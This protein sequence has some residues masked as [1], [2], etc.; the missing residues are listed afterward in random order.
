MTDN[1]A[2]PAYRAG[3]NQSQGYLPDYTA[4][5]YAEMMAKGEDRQTA[6]LQAYN[7]ASGLFLEYVYQQPQNPLDGTRL[8]DNS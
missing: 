3:L 6:Y 2:F 5:L 1:V 4:R 8:W 7:E